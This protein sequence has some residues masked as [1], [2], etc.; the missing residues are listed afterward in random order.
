ML[1]LVFVRF[2]EGEKEWVCHALCG[3][4]CASTVARDD[5]YRCLGVVQ[6]EDLL[7]DALHQ[8]VVVAARVVCASDGTCEETVAAEEDALGCREEAEAAL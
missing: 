7:E 4:V 8:E 3:Q 2:V 1:F 5:F 6:R